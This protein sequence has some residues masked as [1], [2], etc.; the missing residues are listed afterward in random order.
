MN[1]D[2]KEILYTARWLATNQVEPGRARDELIDLLTEALDTEPPHVDHDRLPNP[3]AP[4]PPPA[5]ESTPAQK[6]AKGRI[7]LVVGHTEGTGS[8]SI[9][10]RDEWRTRELVARRAKEM[11]A[12]RG[13]AVRIF[14]RDGRLSYGAAMAAHGRAIDRWQADI[15]IEL[16]FN[17]ATKK[18]TGTECICISDAG[19][20]VA[21]DVCA[22]WH[23][24]FPDLP[25]RRAEGVYR[26]TRGN[27]VGFCRAPRCPAVVWEPFFA[28][29]PEEGPAMLDDPGAEAAG[30]VRGIENYFEKRQ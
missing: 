5:A 17:S 6:P 30:L 16:H 4:K 23:E 26:K 18:A 12:D 13:Y 7:A 1:A 27:G 2:T 3:D 8:Q 19:A 29:H 14:Y 24:D 28:S 25:L 22:G 21:R 20:E 9:D 11:L 10:G 15:A